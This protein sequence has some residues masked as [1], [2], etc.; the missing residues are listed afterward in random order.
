MCV[1]QPDT[2]CVTH[3][4]Q[5]EYQSAK[6]GFRGQKTTVHPIL[7]PSLFFSRG[8]ARFGRCAGNPIGGC[9]QGSP[10]EVAI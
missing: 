10:T 5:K 9:L 7:D 8:A 2:N 4:F 3:T 6:D 1:G